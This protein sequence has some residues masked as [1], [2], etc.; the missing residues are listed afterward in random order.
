MRVCFGV[1]GEFVARIGPLAVHVE[2]DL[3]AFGCPGKD[4]LFALVHESLDFRALTGLK[5]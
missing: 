1:T 5:C 4:E 2:V 3:A